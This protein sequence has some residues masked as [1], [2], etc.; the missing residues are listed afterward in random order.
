MRIDERR[1][2]VQRPHLQ[3]LYTPLKIMTVGNNF[4][5]AEIVFGLRS[6]HPHL[7]NRNLSFH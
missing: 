6:W 7:R 2:F 5:D 3:F 4:I 1:E